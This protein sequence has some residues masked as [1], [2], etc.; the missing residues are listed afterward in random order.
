MK[1]FLY[2]LASKSGSIY[3]DFDNAYATLM[4]KLVDIQRDL[5]PKNGHVFGYKDRRCLYGTLRRSCD[6]AGVKYLGT[7]QL[8]RHSFATALEREGWNS[9]AIAD[10]GGWKSV[11]LVDET[12]IHTNDPAAR[13]TSLIGTKWAQRFGKNS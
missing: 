7:H 10:A 8:G 13:A 1:Q 12:Y 5:E 4:S 11:R 9:K 3:E 6:R 2:K